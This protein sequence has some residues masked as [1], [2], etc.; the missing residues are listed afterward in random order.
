MLEWGFY[1]DQDAVSKLNY[2][3][4]SSILAPLKIEAEWLG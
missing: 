3:A 4:V 1:K 2:E